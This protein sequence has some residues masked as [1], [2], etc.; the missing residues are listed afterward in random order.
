M[1]KK[2]KRHRK[3]MM[4]FVVVIV[5]ALYILNKWSLY[6]QFDT[7]DPE[8]SFGQ[9]VLKVSVKSTE[10][11]LLKD[12]TATDQKDGDVTDSIMIESISNLLEGNQRIVTYVAFD[13]DKHVGKA[14]RRIQYTDYKPIRFTLDEPLGN[15][16]S[17]A[18]VSEILQ[19]L[20]AVDCID[21]DI[22]DQIILVE[23]YWKSD[24]MGDSVTNYKVQVTNSCGEIQEL[25]LSFKMKSE[26]SGSQAIQ[27]SL[28]DYLIYCKAGSSVD[29]NSY[30]ESVEYRGE[31]FGVENV[32]VSTD[33]DTSKP[34]SYVATFKASGEDIQGTCDLIIVVEK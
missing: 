7:S 34:G 8:I 1:K 13:K 33:L 21:G 30:I 2:I 19:P 24:S 17:D 9:D 29:L 10:K 18:S 11:D 3:I 23:A 15:V 26:R 20:H 27:I 22:S 16:D 4:F 32:T 31:D 28:S 5:L 14:E 6:N 25:D 12:V